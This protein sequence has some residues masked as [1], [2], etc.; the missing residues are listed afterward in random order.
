MH[1]YID[2]D[3]KPSRKDVVAEFYVEPNRIKLSKAATHLAGE[4]SIDTWSDIKTLKDSVVKKLAPH[5]YY[6]NE[7]TKTIRIAYPG[8]LFEKG[9]MCQ[10]LSSIAGNVF[11][12]KAVNKLR[13]QDIH[14]PKKFVTSFSGPRI[15]IEGLRKLMNVKKRPFVGT[16]V[17]PKLGLNHKE[18]AQVAYQAWSGGLDIVK[19]DENLTSM[20]F[21]NF[22]KRVDLVLKYLE[23]AEKETGERKLYFP[24]VSAETF[25]MLRRM[26]YVREHG[27]K[28]V[29]VDLLTVG[30]AAVHTLRNK[31]YGLAIHCHRAGHGALTRDPRHGIS[32]LLIAKLA[33]L[34][35]VDSL[36][37]GTANV[38]KMEGKPDEVLK[39]EEEVEDKLVKPDN[40]LHV[41]GQKWYNIKPTLAVASGG[42]QP[43][44]IPLLLKRMGKNI[45][46][47]FG[48]GVHANVYGTKAGAMAVRQS[49]YATLKGIPLQ[50]YAMKHKEL[51]FAVK[52]WGVPK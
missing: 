11:G 12:M 6:I 10:I 1:E 35:G 21:N 8:D 3:Y 52:K 29:M 2:L 25:E 46:M 42:L 23:K 37:V 41:L 24:N 27:G 40:K 32:M 19:D 7:K 16:I 47:M 26:D 13:L 28:A 9:N 31:S 36:H 43:G 51:E 44:S 4:S 48:G 39:I 49:L 38:G 15:G 45:A 5:V 20:T 33:R 30:W 50:K 17:K 34:I 22:K 14:F 18:W